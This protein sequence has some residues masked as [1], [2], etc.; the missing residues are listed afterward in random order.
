MVPGEIWKCLCSYTA[1]ARP[2]VMGPRAAT[3]LANRLATKSART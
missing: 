1:T 3:A 2:T